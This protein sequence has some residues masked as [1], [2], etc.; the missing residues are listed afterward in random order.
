MQARHEVEANAVTAEGDTTD[1][2]RLTQ[3]L[4]KA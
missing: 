4:V 2:S 3:A 1:K